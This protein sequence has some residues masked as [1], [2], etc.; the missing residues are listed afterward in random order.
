MDCQRPRTALPLKFPLRMT[1]AQINAAYPLPQQLE[2]L[3]KRSDS[4]LDSLDGFGGAI[5]WSRQYC[6]RALELETALGE[7]SRQKLN[8][9]AD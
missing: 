2:R 8:V 4:N 5:F 6:I 9:P 1:A 3:G 7:T